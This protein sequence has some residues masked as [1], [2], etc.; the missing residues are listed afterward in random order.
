MGFVAGEVDDDVLLAKIGICDFGAVTVVQ[1]DAGSADEPAG[2]AADDEDDD[3]DAATAADDAVRIA[4]PGP[5]PEGAA[6]P[7]LDA[8]AELTA[9]IA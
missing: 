9:L 8:A 1:E 5:A 7:E 2:A 4:T 6:R 3:T